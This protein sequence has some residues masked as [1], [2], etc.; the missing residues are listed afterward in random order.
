VKVLLLEEAG[1]DPRRRTS[2]PTARWAPTARPRAPGR[3]RAHALQCR[4]ARDGGLR[5]RARRR[6]GGAR[7]ESSPSSGWT[8]PGP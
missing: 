5:H 6:A 4:R 7:A 3:A 2:R 1:G 8:R